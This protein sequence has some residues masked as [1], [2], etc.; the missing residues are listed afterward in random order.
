MRPLKEAVDRLNC[1]KSIPTVSAVF[2]DGSILEMV[3]ALAERRTR[4]VLWKDGAWSVK[5]SLTVDPLHRLV[6]Y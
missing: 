3:Y 1:Q 4:F 2:K 6:P 5:D